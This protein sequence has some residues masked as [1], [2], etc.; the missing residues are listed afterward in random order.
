MRNLFL[1]IILFSVMACQDSKTVTE[2]VKVTDQGAKKVSLEEMP[3]LSFDE[4]NEQWLQRNDD[5]VYVYNFWAT[6]CKPCVKELPYFEQ[7]HEN[8]KD[9][10]VEMV[11]V[12]LDFPKQK[13]T[14]LIPF[15]EEHQLKSKVVHF[16][17][18][19][20]NQWIDKVNPAWSGSIPAT[21]IRHKEE[22][23]F[24]EGTMNYEELSQMIEAFL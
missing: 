24:H 21:L 12:S 16:D 9:K 2:V 22:V 18:K 6:W 5:K 8:Y 14:K 15:I 17:A 20:P 13:T 23:K 11:L 3:T 19:K 10:N 1:L 7:A 4:L